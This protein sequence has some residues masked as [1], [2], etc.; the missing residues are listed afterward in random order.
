MLGDGGAVD[1]EFD[2]R[3]IELDQAIADH[4][5]D[6]DAPL[7]KGQAPFDWGR[8]A[9]DCE[10]LAREADDLR[11]AVWML[12]ARAESEG[13]SGWYRGLCYISE[14]LLKDTGQLF[15]QGDSELPTSDL[16]VT[17]LSWL[18]S[19]PHVA[20]FKKLPLFNGY[21]WPVSALLPEFGGQVLPPDD[22]SA[23]D[24]AL[25][26]NAADP[27]IGRLSVFDMLGKAKQC[28]EEISHRLDEISAD[29]GVDFTELMT[30]VGHATQKARALAMERLSEETPA[31]YEDLECA[32]EESLSR[33]SVGVERGLSLRNREDVRIVLDALLRYYSE[34]ESGH[35]AP[36]FIQR[37]QR[38]IDM[39]FELL[40]RELFSESEMLLNRLVR[41]VSN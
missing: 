30:L 1:L 37:L 23:L 35:P 4:E 21:I 8:V 36:I 39:N 13:L 34:N 20:L 29:R 41:P 15:P 18:A 11:V 28:I 40:M 9:S 2:E 27:G 31:L 25:R 24:S 3:F 7:R 22:R 6:F 10:V 17:V 26:D 38:M 14:L 32:T 16:H 33:V 12:R 5:A 19:S